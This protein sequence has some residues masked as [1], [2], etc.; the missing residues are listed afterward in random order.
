M[1][2]QGIPEIPDTSVEALRLRTRVSAPM[3][4]MA[5]VSS[6]P[7]VGYSTK[8]ADA[9]K[10]AYEIGLSYGDTRANLKRNKVLSRNENRAIE[11]SLRAMDKDTAKRM[12]AQQ[13]NKVN[14]R[15]RFVSRFA[16]EI[17][18]VGKDLYKRVG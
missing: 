2:E 15:D 18:G 16:G 5:D 17:L 13:R 3:P 8:A 12:R 4:G 11:S 6:D 1:V 9:A 7:L 14:G 10:K